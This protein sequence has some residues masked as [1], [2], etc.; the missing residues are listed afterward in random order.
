M[1]KQLL[2]TGA[3]RGI[4]LALTRLYCEAGWDVIACCR[5]PEAAAHLMEL[6]E[7]YEGLE[8][9]ELDVTDFDAVSELADELESRPIDLLINNAGFYGPKGVEFGFTDPESWH[10]VFTINCIAPMK[11][12]EAF[13]PHLAKAKGVIANMSSKM[14]SMTDNTSGGAYLYRSSKAALNSVTRSLAI[15]LAPAGIKVLALHPG[16]VQTEMGGPNAL[17]DTRTSAAGIKAVIDNL[18]ERTHGRLVD[19]SGQVIPW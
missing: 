1:T 5:A 2:I 16:W 14:G 9:F 11:L 3:N 13:F 6:L 10:Q 17:I 15:D 4:G 18:D 12:S 19:F 7:E 8:L